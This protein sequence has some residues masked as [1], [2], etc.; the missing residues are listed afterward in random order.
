MVLEGCVVMMLAGCVVMVLEGCVVMML[1]G[2]VVMLEGVVI[3]EW[4]YASTCDVWLLLYACT[5]C[6]GVIIVHSHT[7]HTHTHL[8]PPHT[9]PHHHTPHHTTP[10]HTTPHHTTHP[11]PH[12]PHPNTQELYGGKS[13]DQLL[14]AL[15]KML[16]HYLQLTGFTCGMDDLL[17]TSSV[18]GWMLVVFACDIVFFCM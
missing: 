16:T 13:A 10:H 11:T 4:V 5:V 9:T 14:N 15:S 18:C 7:H 12:T 17:L 2:C 1:E 6:E 8:A 3:I